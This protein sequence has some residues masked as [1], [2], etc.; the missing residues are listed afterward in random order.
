MTESGLTHL[1]PWVII[2]APWTGGPCGWSKDHQLARV[3]VTLGP[4][5]PRVPLGDTEKA[6]PSGWDIET[7]GRKD[8]LFGSSMEGKHSVSQ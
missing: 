6:L 4:T 7:W 2:L 8:W 1:K 5:G 3:M